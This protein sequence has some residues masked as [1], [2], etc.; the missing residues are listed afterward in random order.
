MENISHSLPKRSF[1]SISNAAFT[2]HKSVY[3]DVFGA[4][5][6]FGLPTLAPRLEDYSEIFGGFHASRSSSI[7]VLDLPLIGDASGLHFDVRSPAFDYTEVFGNFGSLDFTAS[8]EDLVGQSSGGY[9]S[10]DEPWSPAQSG[11]LSDEFDPLAGSDKSHRLSDGDLHQT[12]ESINQFNVSYNKSSQR[13][14]ETVLTGTN[15]VTNLS[16]VPGYTFSHYDSPVCWNGE[17]EHC[18]MRVN[19]DTSRSKE[20]GGRVIAEKHYK[21]CSSNPLRSDFSAHESDFNLLETHGNSTPPDKPFITV[22]DISLR[23]KPSRLPPPSRPPPALGVN[24][25]EFDKS[26][27]K[28]KASKSYTFER[29]ADDGRAIFFDVEIDAA[30]SAE[31][32][33]N[34]NENVKVKHDSIRDSIERKDIWSHD[35]RQVGQKTSKTLR[36]SSHIEDAKMLQS[37]GKETRVS[38]PVIEGRIGSTKSTKETSGSQCLHYGNHVADSSTGAVAW[39]E[40]TEYFEVIEQN[41]PKQAFDMVGDFNTSTQHMNRDAYGHRRTTDPGTCNQKEENKKSKVTMGAH[42]WDEETN[43][44]EMTGDHCDP[45]NKQQK[46]IPNTRF[47]D[48][49]GSYEKVISNKLACVYDS[50]KMIP[51]ILQQLRE[52]ENTQNDNGETIE[53]WPEAKDKV[54]EMEDELKLMASPKRKDIEKRFVDAHLTKQ[55]SGKYNQNI[56]R[57]ECQRRLEDLVGAET[58]ERVMER[59]EPQVIEKQPTG[60]SGREN[61]NKLKETHELNENGMI[62]ELTK[63]HGDS[64]KRLYIAAG[65]EKGGSGQLACKVEKDKERLME[66]GKQKVIYLTDRDAIEQVRNGKEHKLVCESEVM[67]ERN[68]DASRTDDNDLRFRVAMTEASNGGEM[69]ETEGNVD[70]SRDAV[71][72]EELSGHAEEVEPIER[73]KHERRIKQDL[74]GHVLL[75]GEQLKVFDGGCKFDESIATK[76]LGKDRNIQMPELN[77]AVYSSDGNGESKSERNSSAYE[78]EA[79][80]EDTLIKGKFNSFDMNKGELQDGN[81]QCLISNMEESTCLPKQVRDSNICSSDKGI[82]C[83][84]PDKRSPLEY[85]QKP[86]KI[87]STEDDGG[88]EMK[89]TQFVSKRVDASTPS[90]V[91]TESLVNGRKVE[92][93]SSVCEHS[94]DILYSVRNATSQRTE[95]KDKNMKANDQKVGEKIRENELENERLRKL[96]EEREREREREKDRM[97]VDKAALEARERSY[98]EARERAERAAVERATAEVRQRA[99]AGA[100]ERLEKAS[101]E[102]RLRA[103]RSAVERAAAEARHR[104]AEK[105]VTQKAASDAHDLVERSIPDRFSASSRSADRRQSSLSSDLHFRST[106]IP[107]GLRYSY[108]SA[109]VGAEGE[110]PQRCKARL[111]RY[112]RTAER[113]ANALAEKNR[114]D[115]LAQRE[116]EERNRVAEALDAEVKR[117]SSGKEGNLR[118]LLST[119]QYILGPDSGWQ[120]VPLTEVITSAAVKK[121]YRK[122]TLC[123]HP[124]KLQQRGATIQQKY[125]CEKVFDLL[126]EAW[127]KFN[128][129]ER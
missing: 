128:S 61:E 72:M 101:M 18:P 116:R 59:T 63:S 30:L 122:A 105:S 46:E 62:F 83:V 115:L 119:L 32:R 78:S 33:A 90:Q 28:P 2:S 87:M 81:N 67:E 6:K 50:N 82:S 124:D 120:P 108:S 43:Q 35:A 123:V 22:S 4:P 121:A 76:V 40:A 51:E 111:E 80:I 15:L 99:V 77:Q 14:I 86:E 25:G 12:L 89:G 34:G 104:A 1:S 45:D 58:I 64:G 10:S 24:N 39:R 66:V 110:S 13:N 102:A 60:V 44:P 97:A 92:G 26:N 95:R 23:T 96:E 21:K 65:H 11:S 109:H 17:D 114:R 41:V 129:E 54:F 27:S 73:N 29:V 7:P 127:N 56:L 117:W 125:I 68:G 49:Q 84:M 5:P 9:E 20:F 36:M 53:G 100:R 48:H 3:D 55:N 85:S 126:K 70:R 112:R 42:R 16:A 98:T 69:F 107:N 103:E 113:A 47:S 93:A 75:E 118:A 88:Q 8:F 37:N 74:H 38:A 79:G 91:I 19:D 57:E 71:V 106:G 52:S 94:D 31:G